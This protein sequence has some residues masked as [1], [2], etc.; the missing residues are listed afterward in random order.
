MDISNYDFQTA[1]HK[2]VMENQEHIVEFLLKKCNQ[3]DIALTAT[4]R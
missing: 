1:L 2:A 4:D 3:T